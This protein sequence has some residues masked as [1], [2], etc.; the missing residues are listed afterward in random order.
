VAQQGLSPVEISTQI[1][2]IL[3]KDNDQGMFVTMFIGK[4]DLLTGHLDYCNCG[5]NAPIIDGHFLEMQ[6][7]NQPLGL[8]EDDPFYGESIDNIKGK[9][10][11]LYTDG[12]NEAE[13][14]DKK[15]LGNERLL[16]LVQGTQDMDSH[17][18]VDKLVAAVEEH[19]AGVDPNDDLTLLCLKIKA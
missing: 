10:L 12:L 11:L 14:S 6:Y 8:W 1:N 2:T 3:A 19:R 18:V 16:E 15:Q 13:N 5:H 7:D 17:Q 4:V 9:Q